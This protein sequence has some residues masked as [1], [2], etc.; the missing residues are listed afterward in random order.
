MPEIVVN[1]TARS[2]AS[3]SVE[4]LIRELDL[5]EKK[6]AIEMNNAVIPRT[7]FPATPIQDGDSLEVVHFVGGG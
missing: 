3:T 5:V 4:E 1:G 6:F 7:S 2:V